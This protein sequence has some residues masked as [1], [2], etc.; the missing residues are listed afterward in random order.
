MTGSE[1]RAPGY[2]GK[3]RVVVQSVKLIVHF[4]HVIGCSPT[5]RTSGSLQMVERSAYVVHAG[6]Y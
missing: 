2:E 6:R 1:P 3:V 5:D 4:M